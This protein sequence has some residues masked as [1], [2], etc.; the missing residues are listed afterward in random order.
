MINSSTSD[1]RTAQTLPGDQS[2][3]VSAQQRMNR[4][5]MDPA[6]WSAR[7]TST[8]PESD[9]YYLFIWPATGRTEPREET[10]ASL[11][12]FSVEMTD[13]LPT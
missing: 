7:A 8:A 10:P 9:A 4:L 12:T 1:Q 3:F 6:E 2:S 11:A 13:G 5:G